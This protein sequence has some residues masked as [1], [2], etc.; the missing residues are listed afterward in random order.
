MKIMQLGKAAA[1]PVFGE[2]N[3]CYLISC[4]DKL[5]LLETPPSI[6][7]QLN[8]AKIDAGKPRWIFISHIHG[9]HSIGLPM[10]LLAGYLKK[11]SGMYNIICRN[12][13][14]FKLRQTASIFFPELE[15]YINS[16]VR[17]YTMES[18]KKF[19][20][21]IA[22]DCLIS[23][24]YGIHGMPSA[25]IRVD[26][27]GKS[28]VYSGDTAYCENIALLAR[29]TDILI[30]EMGGLDQDMSE[31]QKTNHSS[32]QD[33]AITAQKS[34]CKELWF[35]HLRTVEMEYNRQ[36]IEQACAYCNCAKIKI[37]PDFKWIEV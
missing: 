14:E 24:D 11:S 25:G 16:N 19:N 37:A 17:F 32:A 4:S 33:A 35:T 28:V 26:C 29:N 30:H 34:G 31:K 21:K 22:G 36:C 3:V 7:N 27:A 13:V 12:D 10:F 23:C 15:E 1:V 8:S 6:L 18:D 9:D 2:Y 20:L 5:I